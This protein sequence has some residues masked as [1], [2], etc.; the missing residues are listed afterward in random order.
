MSTPETPRI[1][2]LKCSP[3]VFDDV[4]RGVKTF[5]VRRNDRR[6]C[7]GD[8]LWLREYEPTGAT[9][10]GREC[11]RQVTYVCDLAPFGIVGYVG[12]SLVPAEVRPVGGGVVKLRRRASKDEPTPTFT[13][14]CPVRLHTGDGAFV[15]RCYYA[16]YGGRCCNHGDVAQ[17]LVP[18]A[19]LAD[20]DDRKIVRLGKE[21]S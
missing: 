2:E 18:N 1:H 16:T 11:R 9:Y 19:D 6:F 14:S 13:G 15:G 17:W 5:E 4:E 20:A 12:M 8:W 3:L 10:S 21:E 7:A